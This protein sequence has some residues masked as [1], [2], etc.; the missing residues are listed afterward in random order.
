MAPSPHARR[1]VVSSS[2]SGP[3]PSPPL[4]SSCCAFVRPPAPGESQPARQGGA[5]GD[6]YSLAAAASAPLA[7]LS[8]CTRARAALKAQPRR[9]VEG[10]GRV[11]GEQGR[12]GGGEAAEAAMAAAAPVASKGPPGGGAAIV[13]GSRCFG[14]FLHSFFFTP[15]RRSLPFFRASEP[16][17]AV[18]PHLSAA[19]GP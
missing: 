12:R 15:S 9:S 5:E 1:I 17:A 14:L 6:Y 16:F 19:P 7:R 18:G 10:R 13:T 3:L 4:P 8:S 2:S 11:E